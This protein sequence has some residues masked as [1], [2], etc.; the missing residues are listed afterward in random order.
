MPYLCLL[1]ADVVRSVVT[2]GICSETLLPVVWIFKYLLC[3]H[4]VSSRQASTAG[5]EQS[6][7]QSGAQV[8]KFL[9]FPS[10]SLLSDKPCRQ[11]SL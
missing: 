2:L 11:G 7:R 8:V 6:A 5:R 10:A 1:T 9:C 4:H 3:F